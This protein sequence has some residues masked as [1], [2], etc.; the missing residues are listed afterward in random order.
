MVQKIRIG[1]EKFYKVLCYLGGMRKEVVYILGLFLFLSLI[2]FAS[3]GC[4]DP[5]DSNQIIMKLSYSPDTSNL[6][7]ALWNQSYS[8][9]ICYNDRF[10][11]YK[12]EGNPHDGCDSKDVLLYLN[13]VTNAHAANESSSVYNIPVCHKGLKDCKIG[14][15]CEGDLKCNI[16]AYVSGTNNTH[17]SSPGSYY[18]EGSIY[19]PITCICT[20]EDCSRRIQPVV[21]GCYD[22]SKSNSTCEGDGNAEGIAQL[23]PGCNANPKSLCHCIWNASAATKCSVKWNVQDPNNLECEYSCTV[24]GST[25]T[26]CS[27]GSQVMRTLATIT[28]SS[29][30]NCPTTNAAGI[31]NCQSGSATI[32]CGALEEASLP[33]FGAWQFVISLISIAFVYALLERKRLL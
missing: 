19:Q 9:N 14:R 6:H 12:G 26:E 22:F 13:N 28:S 27:G 33:F 23:D 11:K 24:S 15:D 21:T 25:A 3:A 10:T 5:D 20:G 32:P 4:S 29:P 8:L 30:T 17:I 31:I 7:G 1:F 2:G 16:I 18:P